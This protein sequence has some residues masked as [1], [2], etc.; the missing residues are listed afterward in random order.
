METE[1]S[2]LAH[3]GAYREAKEMRARLT[4]LRGE[5]DNLQITGASA[6]RNDQVSLYETGSKTLLAM[7]RERQ[8]NQKLETEHRCELVRADLAQTHEIQ[9][10]NCEMEI[11]RIN[12]P[13]TKYSKRMIELK[14]AEAGYILLAP[15]TVNVK[16]HFTSTEQI[17]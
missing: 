11:S 13:P 9:N 8:R 10:E 5:F 12:M 16:P 3:S 14:K 15:L 2:R 4:F 6:I 17:N 1:I 7:E